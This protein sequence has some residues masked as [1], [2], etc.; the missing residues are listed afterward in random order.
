ME[1]FLLDLGQPLEGIG[2]SDR[3][4]LA[5]S[6]ALQ[7]E[8]INV[9]GFWV[10]EHHGEA[11]F[12]APEVMISSIASA[13]SRL[14]V[15]SG[16]VLISIHSVYATAER[17]RLLSALFPNRIEIGVAR[18]KPP[19]N[20]ISQ[21]G[22]FSNETYEQRVRGLRTALLESRSGPQPNDCQAPPIWLLGMGSRSASLAGELGVNYCHGLFLKG[23]EPLTAAY[24]TYTR[25]L[26]VGCNGCFG[27][28]MSVAM[29]G[30]QP[31]RIFA[32]TYARVN[33]TI[34]E[35]QVIENAMCLASGVVLSR[36]VFVSA[37]ASAKAYASIASHLPGVAAT[38]GCF[39]SSAV[40]CK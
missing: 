2:A 9:D 17:F 32:G 27:V 4:R 35:D 25:A 22:D 20:L 3:V 40:T 18:G 24:E 12:S 5:V 28:A 16:G 34:D 38:L 33:L 10:G 29:S 14:R 23:A 13:T 36:T 21:F 1:I 37:A 7:M 15:G 30:E 31:A 11:A 19:D 8:E 39:K 26:P 6:T